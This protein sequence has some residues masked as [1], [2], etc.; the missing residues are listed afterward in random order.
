MTNSN[1]F[2]SYRMACFHIVEIGVKASAVKRDEV[3]GI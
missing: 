2:L 3:V 1:G